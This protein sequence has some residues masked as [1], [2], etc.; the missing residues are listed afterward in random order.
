MDKRD[1]VIVSACRTP[2]GRLMGGLGSIPAT[3]LGGIVIREAVTRAGVAP[4][5]RDEPF[6]NFF[7]GG[8]GNN[9][10]D[11]GET[12]R[13]REWYAFPGF[14]LNELGGT[15]F[16]KAMVDWNLPPLRFRRLG[17]PV[18]PPDEESELPSEA[19]T[20]LQPAGVR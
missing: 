11:R 17:R 19:F 13:Y 18:A 20:N 4:T 5:D 6:S 15:N 16:V 3:D 9:W 7:L 10:V 12:K 2:M 1:A 8:F 14:E